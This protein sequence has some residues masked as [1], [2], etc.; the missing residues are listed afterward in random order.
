[1]KDFIIT[2]DSCSDLPLNLVKEMDLRVIPLSVEIDGNVYRDYPD[3]REIKVKDFYELLRDKKVAKTSMI[4]VNDF[5][6]FFEEVLKEGKDILYIGFSSA[7]SG[8]VNSASLAKEEIM[9][10]YPN[11]KIVIIDS[12]SASLGLGLLIFHADKLRRAG[13]TIDEVASWV[14]DNKL[15]LCHLFT[16]A[17]LGTL[18]RGGRLSGT[19]AFFGDLLRVK[20]VM[21]VS[22]EGKLVP[23]KKA[24]GRASSLVM[25]VEMMKEGIV[26]PKKQTIFLSHGDDLETAKNVG[27]MIQDEIGVKKIIY[28]NVGPIIGAHSGPGTIAIFFLG[29][30]R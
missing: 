10:K 14:E 8:T 2:A 26:E 7:L 3:E 11:R 9:D 13:K 29:N 22:N 20:P 15:K 28:G 21:H 27:K 30:E 6:V 12:L 23:L 19:A 25:L 5:I 24:R 4:N 18:R 1:M 16:V 17:D